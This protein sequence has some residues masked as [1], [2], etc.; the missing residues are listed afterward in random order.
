MFG[1]TNY[2]I[3]P[4]I[5]YL[6]TENSYRHPGTALYVHSIAVGSSNFMV[7][8][9]IYQGGV[10]LD[11]SIVVIFIDLNQIYSFNKIFYSYD[12]PTISHGFNM[13]PDC[14]LQSNVNNS[15]FPTLYGPILSRNCSIGINA[16]FTINNGNRK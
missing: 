4:Y 16:I 14:T 11:L 9:D 13:N 10:V 1:H 15:T 5:S 2:T 6:K 12:F 7:R 3:L 8:A